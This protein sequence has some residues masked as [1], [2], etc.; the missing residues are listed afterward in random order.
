MIQ[1]NIFE[2]MY[3]VNIYYLFSSC[4]FPILDYD[5]GVWGSKE[6]NEID[7]VQEKAIRYFL[8]VHR[9]APIHML[10]GDIGWISCLVQ[11]KSSVIRLWNRLAT[12]SPSRVTSKV[13][14]WD[15]LYSCKQGTWSYCVK[16]YSLISIFRTILIIPFHAQLKLQVDALMKI[17]NIYGTWKDMASLSYAI[18][19][20]LKMIYCQW[21]T[22]TSIFRNIRGLYLPNSGPEFC[23][24]MLKQVAFAI[25]R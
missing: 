6:F 11:H 8:G 19:I 15:L 4:V 1:A 22:Q 13:F 17:T 23:P 21:N 25:Y 14:H 3:V 16:N 2:R 12:L 10:Y 18:I 5:A 7:R 9:F 24:C 20:C